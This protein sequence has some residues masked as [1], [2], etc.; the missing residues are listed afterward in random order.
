MIGKVTGQGQVIRWLVVAVQ[1]NP[2]G[3]GFRQQ[4]RWRQIC[5]HERYRGPLAQTG[6][7]GGGI[8]TECTATDLYPCFHLIDWLRLKEDDVA[9]CGVQLSIGSL[10][11]RE[12]VTRGRIGIKVHIVGELIQAANSKRPSGRGC[13]TT[14][15]RTRA[16][17]HIIDR[18]TGHCIGGQC[19]CTAGRHFDPVF[20]RCAFNTCTEVQGPAVGFNLVSKINCALECATRFLRIGR[21]C[22]NDTVDRILLTVDRQIDQR[23]V[24]VELSEI[25]NGP[26]IIVRFRPRHEA[27]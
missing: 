24:I 21:R 25:L 17:G 20:D 18:R 22:L 2:E 6:V 13:L 8:T 7:E 3:V 9:V 23:W 15:E 5:T 10:R 11:L 12:E 1:F 4:Q 27:A 19:S 26:L 16:K 14:P